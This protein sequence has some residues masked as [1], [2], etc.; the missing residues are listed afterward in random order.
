MKA[1]MNAAALAANQDYESK[2]ST[3]RAHLVAAV[4]AADR[5]TAAATNGLGKVETEVGYEKAIY[6]YRESPTDAASSI[7]P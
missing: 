5:V 2:N 6:E 4:N 7:R 3:T 1:A